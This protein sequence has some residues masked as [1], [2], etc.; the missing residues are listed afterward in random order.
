VLRRTGLDELPQLV[1]VLSGKMSLVG[2]R[3]ELPEIVAEYQPWQFR[4]FAV[5]PG[6]TGWWQVNRDHGVPM[7]FQ[8]ELDVHYLI[9][10]SFLLDVEI[11]V[12]TIA[13]LVRGRGA[14]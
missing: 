3:P 14:Y 9:H 11:L 12:R 13:V 2:P 7:H 5:P 1:H 8:T 6:I 10:Y 4:R